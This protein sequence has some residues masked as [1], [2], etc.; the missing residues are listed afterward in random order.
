MRVCLAAVLSLYVLLTQPVF[1]EET[2]PYAGYIT[3][4]N[5]YV[6]SGPG[7]NYYPTSKLRTGDRVE[8]YRHDPGGWYAIRPVEGSFSWVSGRYLQVREDGLAKL[9][10]DRV[11]AR[12]GS[13]FS[14][15]R[16]VIQVRLHEG[17]LVEVLAEKRVGSGPESGTWYK[18]APPSGEF[19]WVFG[20]FIDPH[21][22]QSG[23]RN[24]PAEY[25]PL[26]RSGQ[27]SPD[28]VA[29][30]GGEAPAQGTDGPGGQG[31]PAA[32]PP[33]S[34]VRTAELWSA[35][36]GAATQGPEPGPE[37][38]PPDAAGA[39]TANRDRPQQDAAAG[40]TNRF[41]DPAHDP[42]GSLTLRRLS[43]EEL[44]AELEEI[45]VELSIM[46]AEEPTVWKLDDL[47]VRTQALLTEAETA[48]E[49]GRVRL[50]A[51]KIAQSED[52][53]RRYDAVNGTGMATERRNRQLSDLAKAREGSS[54]EADPARRFD[55]VGRLARVMPP[56]LGAPRFALV[57]QNGDVRCYVT[58]APGLNLNYYVGQQ[59]G[60]NGSRGYIA[61]QRIQHVTAKHV[62]PF[63]ATRLR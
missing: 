42:A 33:A 59:V 35:P 38:R 25:H 7:R 49:R 40:H 51:N 58:P 30:A 13:Q 32:A 8:V 1:G 37:Q 60:I 31:Q 12:V 48:V 56:K 19:R 26:V 57:D 24:A 39:A 4:E 54:P 55:G 47:V 28:Q 3:A 61:D 29:A 41:V 34:D 43:P 62:T 2:F 17:E 15:I 23:V 22:H 52:I 36:S 63:A 9:T 14:D 18:I 11:A 20:K 10:A 6:R 44:Q 5:V 45:D 21:Y 27:S 53:K 16:D 46:L 50:L